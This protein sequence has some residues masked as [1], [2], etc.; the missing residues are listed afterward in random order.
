[1]QLSIELWPARL[2]PAEHCGDPSS[3]HIDGQTT[4]L[5][6]DRVSALPEKCSEVAESTKKIPLCKKSIQ[7]VAD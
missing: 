1:M 3:G 7:V 4:K 2:C 6:S 5:S